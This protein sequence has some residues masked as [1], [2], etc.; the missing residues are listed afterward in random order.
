EWDPNYRIKNILSAVRRLFVKSSNS[1]SASPAKRIQKVES[2]IQ[3]EIIELQNE[4]TRHNT[5]INNYRNQQIA[6]SNTQ[7]PVSAIKI[8]QK[9]DFESTIG[10]INDLL[11]LLSMKFEEAEIE[12]TDF[13][14]L[15]RRYAKEYYIKVREYELLGG[16]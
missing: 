2:S 10:A 16:N 6:S 14:R 7:Q 8:T 3:K 5:L 1:I 15:Y 12:Q 4:I 13:F 11:E 9:S